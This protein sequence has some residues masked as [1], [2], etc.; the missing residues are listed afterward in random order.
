LSFISFFYFS[1]SDGV[2]CAAKTAYF[3]PDEEMVAAHAYMFFTSV[4]AE[5]ERVRTK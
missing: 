2:Y 1:V 4:D 5:D 3:P